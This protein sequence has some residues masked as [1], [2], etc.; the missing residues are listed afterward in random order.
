M[1]TDVDCELL[2]ASY[3]VGLFISWTVGEFGVGY[4]CIIRTTF[5]S[6]I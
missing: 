3:C 4:T 5:D 1:H 2:V 6:A